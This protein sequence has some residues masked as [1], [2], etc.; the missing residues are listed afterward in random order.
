MISRP[1]VQVPKAS[2]ESVAVYLVPADPVKKTL[3][4]STQ[5]N[6]VLFLFRPLIYKVIGYRLR[7]DFDV[8]MYS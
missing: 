1:P 4:D 2:A 8:S 6:E 7:G 3:R 5:R